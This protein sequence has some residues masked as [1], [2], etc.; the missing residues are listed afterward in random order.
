MRVVP[1]L[2]LIVAIGCSEEAPVGYGREFAA[3]FISA[4]RSGVDPSRAEAVCVC[5][6]GRIQADTPF[7]ELPPLD[8][9]T[10][11]QASPDV[12]DPSYYDRLADCVLDA[13]A[14]VTLPPGTV[15]R[16]TLPPATV[17]ATSLPAEGEVVG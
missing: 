11:A 1:A 9:L 12:V 13:G 3:E 17:P 14:T 8:D 15:P 6:Y 7:D 10:S 16:P 5:W 2:L 4:C